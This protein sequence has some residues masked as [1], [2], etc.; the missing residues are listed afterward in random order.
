MTLKHEYARVLSKL[1]LVTPE[2]AFGE[3]GLLVIAPHP[4]DESLGCGGLIAW[5][6]ES[7]RPVKVLFLTDGEGSHPGS[8]RFPPARLSQVRI[9]EAVDA[10]AILGVVERDA[11]FLHLT[12]GG[13]SSMDRLAIDHARRSLR[14]IIGELGACDV[15]VTACADP[16]GDHQAAFALARNVIECE[17]ACRLLQYPVW[18]W[19]QA[20]PKPRAAPAGFRVDFSSTLHLKRR[21]ISAHF[22]QH[23]GLVTDSPEPFSLPPE[24]IRH[25]TSGFEVFLHA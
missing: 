14:E 13:L 25:V 16:H 19:M 2:A 6:C 7:G 21:A 17:P 15:L 11:L 5:G 9:Q 18:S 23:G 22:S 8:R 20:S 24:L 1:P 4:D 12:D 10:L 3:R